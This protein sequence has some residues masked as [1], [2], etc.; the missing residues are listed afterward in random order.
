MDVLPSILEW[1]SA[2]W[3]LPC[4]CFITLVS[5][6]LGRCLVFRTCQGKTRGPVYQHSAIILPQTR[7]APL[8]QEVF[9]LLSWAHKLS[10]SL[11]L[12]VPRL[13][14]KATRADAVAPAGEELILELVLFHTCQDSLHH[15][16]AHIIRFI[17]KRHLHP[18]EH[19]LAGDCQCLSANKKH[20]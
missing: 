17:Q 8:R 19:L 4:M 1:C 6:C 15:F 10:R 13:S 16:S 7:L 14:P 9:Q 12:A 11:L 3:F 5:K 18:P 20:T 2:G